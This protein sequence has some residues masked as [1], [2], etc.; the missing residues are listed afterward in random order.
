[1]D[2]KI[3]HKLCLALN[4]ARDKDTIWPVLVASLKSAKPNETCVRETLQAVG[5]DGFDDVQLKSYLPYIPKLLLDYTGDDYDA[6]LRLQPL[7]KLSAPKR[8]RPPPSHE[9]S[10][11]EPPAKRAHVEPSITDHIMASLN[12]RSIRLKFTVDQHNIG[13]LLPD[14]SP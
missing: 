5:A 4:E 3:L 14:S 13:F 12:N 9:K 2:E 8:K 1:M 10:E 11:D 6:W 7:P